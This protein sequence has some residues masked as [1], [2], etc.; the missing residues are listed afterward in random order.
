MKRGTN[1]MQELVKY[2][3]RT[4]CKQNANRKNLPRIQENTSAS[5]TFTNVI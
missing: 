3:E 2:E 5:A 1:K 4:Y